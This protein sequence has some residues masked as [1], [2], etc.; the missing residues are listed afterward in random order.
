MT[1]NNVLGW[2]VRDLRIYFHELVGELLT[3][4]VPL[5]LGEPD[6]GFVGPVPLAIVAFWLRQVV[7]K[8]DYKWG[9]MSAL[10][11]I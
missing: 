3:E 6:A 4:R 9:L 7:Q 2:Q 10:S 11:R 1:H 5:L 8:V